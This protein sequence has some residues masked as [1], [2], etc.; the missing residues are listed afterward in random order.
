MT[1][2]RIVKPALVHDEY[3]RKDLGVRS[4][5]E[6]DRRIEARD[7]YDH[8]PSGGL[9]T[10]SWPPGY[11][12]GPELARALHELGII[13]D[14]TG[15]SNEGDGGA[16]PTFT[17]N[18]N[19]GTGATMTV[20]GSDVAGKLRLT[21]GTGPGTGVVCT[22]TF[23]EEL[24]TAGYAV[25]LFAAGSNAA[26]AATKVYVPQDELLSTRWRIWVT[27]AL[28]ASTEHWW[29]YKVEPYPA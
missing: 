26:L 4:S 16:T 7:A 19:A 21:T 29:Y 11:D 13:N 18:S 3:L 20:I 6:T 10:G 14:Q 17:T 2:K 24:L 9:V 12:A 22:V 25:Q 15:I 27:S 5:R 1:T 23:A 28:P 8:A